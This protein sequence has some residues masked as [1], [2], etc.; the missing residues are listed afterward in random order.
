MAA[1]LSLTVRQLLGSRKV[2]LVA[3][4][5]SLPVLAGVL[6][7]VADSTRTGDEFADRITS[8][9]LVS[10]ILPLVL[11]LLGTASF[12]NEISDR[13]LVYLFTKPLERWRIVAAKLAAPIL[14]GGLPVAASGAA[15]VAVIGTGD[16]GGAA[17]TGVGL[18]V[19]AAA[20]AALF[21]WLGLSTRHGLVIGLVYVFVWEAVLAAYL[22][23]V[24]Y[25]SVRRFTLAV[26]DGLDDERLASL[27]EPLGGVAGA[28][29][30]AIVLAGFGALTVRRL[31]RLDVP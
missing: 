10:A 12:G 24:R 28:V 18:L 14:V 26:I 19:G 1:V 11:L 2:W 29:L 4:L 31:R 21:T 7:H 17:A 25:L 9:L 23:G 3:A 5:V 13:T 22:D 15:A 20:Y 6:F 16:P 27:D 30:A 8:R